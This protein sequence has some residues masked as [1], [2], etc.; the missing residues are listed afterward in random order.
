MTPFEGSFSV[1]G[2]AGLCGDVALTPQYE[3]A[4]L[5]NASPIQYSQ[6]DNEFLV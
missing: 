5:T 4:D 6:N 3:G 2:G 1:N